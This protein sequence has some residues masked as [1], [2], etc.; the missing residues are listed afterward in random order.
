MDDV[1]AMNPCMLVGLTGG[2]GAG[3]STAEEFVRAWHIPVA[4]ADHW[5][6]AV[7]A[8]ER[9]AQRAI[10]DYFLAHHGLDPLRPDG[11]LDRTMLA[12]IVFH[13]ATALAFL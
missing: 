13:D 10:Q 1:P 11:T 7:L 2:V 6:H 4:D 3:K 12:R 5:A 8:Q 9:Q